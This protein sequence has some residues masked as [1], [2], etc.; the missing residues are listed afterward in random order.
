MRSNPPGRG[1]SAARGSRGLT[2]SALADTSNTMDEPDDSIDLSYLENILVTIMHPTCD[3]NDPLVVN[4]KKGQNSV[5]HLRYSEDLRDAECWHFLSRYR[6]CEDLG[7]NLRITY[8][9]SLVQSLEMRAPTHPS[10][11]TQGVPLSW[12][13]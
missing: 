12:Y 9:R 3:H 8:W 7:N 11:C 2:S 4:Y 10:N 6:V 13:N 5:A 1:K